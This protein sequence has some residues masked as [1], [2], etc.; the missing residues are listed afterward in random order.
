M[1]EDLLAKHPLVDMPLEQVIALLGA[2]DSSNHYISYWLGPRLGNFDVQNCGR[3]SFYFQDEIVSLVQADALPSAEKRP[4]KSAFER[5]S[6][7]TAS[8]QERL[9]ML[10]GA[11]ARGTSTWAAP[12]LTSRPFSAPRTIAHTSCGTPLVRAAVF[13]LPGSEY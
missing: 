6:W 7:L 3:F 8:T 13:S 11:L 1:C 4:L 5:E 9:A 10:E 12:A 2:P